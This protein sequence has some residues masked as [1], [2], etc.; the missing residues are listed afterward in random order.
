MN[1]FTK[2]DTGIIAGPDAPR[3]AAGLE[4]NAHPAFA[5]VSLKHL[6]TGHETE[7]RFSAHLVRLEPGAE[8]GDH[9]HETNWE[10]HEVA[11]GS[12][13]CFLDG[14]CIPYEPGVVAIMPESASHRV[15]AGENG[16]CLLAKFMPALL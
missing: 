14:K 10:L 12:G 13:Q 16:L 11:E 7:G 4:W 15:Q 9:V 8:I 1:I 6:I 5:G 2:F 3:G